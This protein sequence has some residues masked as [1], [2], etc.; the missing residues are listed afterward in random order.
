MT[1]FILPRSELQNLNRDVPDLMPILLQIMSDR[2][3]HLAHLSE[4]LGAWSV[5]NRIN[6]CLVTYADHNLPTPV[7]KITHEKLAALAGTAREVVTRHLSRLERDGA[8]QLES[9]KIILLDVQVLQP[10]CRAARA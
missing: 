1:L 6:D 2:Y 10:I 3:T 5:A 4:G 9:G 8:I 7:T